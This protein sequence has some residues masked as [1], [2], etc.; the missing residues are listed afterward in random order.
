VLTAR[1]DDAIEC[2]SGDDTYFSDAEVHPDATGCDQR[3]LSPARLRE[4][5]SETNL[6]VIKPFGNEAGSALALTVCEPRR[7]IADAALA[8]ALEYLERSDTAL[9]EIVFL[10]GYSELAAFAHAFR[11]WTGRRPGAHRRSSRQ[12]S[13]TDRRRVQRQADQKDGYRPLRKRG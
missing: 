1:T 3:F 8:L 6:S 12:P 11:R 7:G 5:A 10:L 9:A 2:G 4:V 13:T